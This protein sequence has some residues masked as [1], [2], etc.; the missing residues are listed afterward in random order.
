MKR[1]SIPIGDSKGEE[2][3]LGSPI[4]GLQ[5][6]YSQHFVDHVFTNELAGMLRQWIDHWTY[7][8]GE[9][10]TDNYYSYNGH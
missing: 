6:S 5:L 4:K 1:S 3:V 7:R 9:Y 8:A 2:D 10:S